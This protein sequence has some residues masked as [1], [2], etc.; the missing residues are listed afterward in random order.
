MDH[1]RIQ[2]DNRS[3]RIDLK[4]G[5]SLPDFTM[6]QDGSVIFY[7]NRLDNPVDTICYMFAPMVRMNIADLALIRKLTHPRI[8]ALVS[9]RDGGISG[10][11]PVMS[12]DVVRIYAVSFVPLD[13]STKKP[14][15]RA[16]VLLEDLYLIQWR[17]L[18]HWLATKSQEEYEGE[19]GLFF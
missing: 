2:F 4:T 5:L 8:W 16:C 3:Q 12:A 11:N 13:L 18:D 15:P 1:I 14:L 7:E 19:R 17:E 9:G 6:V 10:L